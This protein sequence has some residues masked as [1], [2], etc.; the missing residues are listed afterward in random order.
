VLMNVSRKNDEDALTPMLKIWAKDA[1]E[2]GIQFEIQKGLIFLIA[3]GLRTSY[4][5]KDIDDWISFTKKL[6]TKISKKGACMYVRTKDGG[7]FHDSNF[8]PLLTELAERV[9]GSDFS[10]RLISTHNIKVW[11]RNNIPNQL[12]ECLNCGTWQLADWDNVMTSLCFQIGKEIHMDL[13]GAYLAGFLYFDSCHPADPKATMQISALVT[14]M[15]PP[16]FMWFRHLLDYDVEQIAQGNSMQKILDCFMSD[17]AA[18][19]LLLYKWITYLSDQLH[20]EAA[21][22]KRKLIWDADATEFTV[23]VVKQRGWIPDDTTEEKAAV[24]EIRQLL[25][26]KGFV[27]P[28]QCPDLES[29]I[30]IVSKTIKQ[31]WGYSIQHVPDSIAAN[32]WTRR[33]CVLFTSVAFSVLNPRWNENA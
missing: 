11:D 3:F 5:P 24:S 13:E 8:S 18:E 23:A 33:C 28:G 7:D 4:R 15:L 9:L 25:A 19:S 10:P 1:D 6:S 2:F 12:A 32:G 17:V 16:K 21:G 14:E 22:V 26:K 30:E 27:A 31:R 29:A 20:Y